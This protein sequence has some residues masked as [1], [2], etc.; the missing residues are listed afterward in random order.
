MPFECGFPLPS[1]ERVR[2]RG[3]MAELKHDN[4]LSSPTPNS[5]RLI[6]CLGRF[7][8]QAVDM[9]NHFSRTRP[10]TE[11]ETEHLIVAFGRRAPHP[12]TNEQ[13]GNE[14]PID[15]QLHA[16]GALTEQVAT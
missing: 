8:L 7:E 13:A 1:R 12:Q 10:A 9:R 5:V 11:I 16:V 15:L 14:R 3:R 4:P 2:V 6:F